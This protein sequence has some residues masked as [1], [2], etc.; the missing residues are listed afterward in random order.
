MKILI[1]FVGNICTGKTTASKMIADYFTC[2][3]YSIDEYRI[4]YSAFDKIFEAVAWDKMTDSIKNEN[5][6]VVESSGLSINIRHIYRLFDKVIVIKLFSS[7][8]VI[9]KRIE[10]RKL[11]GYV[12]VPFCYGSQYEPKEIK[13]RKIEKLVSK[14]KFDFCI[15]T[16]V[17]S[18]NDVF[19]FLKNNIQL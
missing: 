1:S 3:C 17:N 12:R 19:I 8:A 4:K 11:N 5:I 14:L 16:D 13:V 2:N 6:A 7:E 15:N 9:L 18:I 10:E